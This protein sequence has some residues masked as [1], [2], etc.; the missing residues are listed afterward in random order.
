[1]KTGVRDM[2]I[3]LTALLGI[4]GFAWMLLI[5]GEL[6]FL[7]A[8]TYPVTLQLDQA[9]G[10]TRNSPVT[11]AGIKIGSIDGL[12][13]A[14][15]PREGVILTLKI[16][17]RVRV[18]RDVS[19]M[20]D[21][22]F[23]GDTT[24]SFSVP[25]E[26]PTPD[27]GFLDPGETLKRQSRGLLDQLSGILD[28]RLG[29]LDEAARSFKELSETYVRVGRRAEEFLAPRTSAEVDAGQPANLAS[30]LQRLDL[31][32]ADAR[33]WLGDEGLRTDARQAVNQVTEV[34]RRAG[35]LVDAWTLAAADLRAGAA[36]VTQNV[37]SATRDF[38]TLTRGMNDALHEV[39]SIAARINQGEGT[40]GQLVTN[41]DLYRSLDDA[42]KRLEKA[43]LEAQLLIE[44]YRKEGIPIQ[45]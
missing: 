23:V 38:A 6:S 1:M 42:A 24:L 5:F 22:G 39:R 34:M 19:V 28:S 4:A 25:P 10:L 17:E 37:E 13:T 40:I 14:A 8:A 11:L 9:G 43:L 16:D 41:P 21:R 12:A 26:R 7:R 27:P 3:G 15:D 36:T 35:E 20:L 33:G 29:A 30:T 44:K 2:F 31:A 32:L 18:P 45:W